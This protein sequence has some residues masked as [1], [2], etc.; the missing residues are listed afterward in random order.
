MYL[1]VV[2]DKIKNIKIYGDFFSQLN[3][4]DLENVLVGVKYEKS[5]IEKALANLD[6]NCYMKGIDK[7]DFISHLFKN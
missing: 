1:N 2:E 3:I 5:E 6:F 7:Q 4:S